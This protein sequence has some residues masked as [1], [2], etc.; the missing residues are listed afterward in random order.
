[1]AAPCPRSAQSRLEPPRP[2]RGPARSPPR[3]RPSATTRADSDCPAVTSG[4]S[5]WRAAQVAAAPSRLFAPAA[6]LPN[7]EVVLRALALCKQLRLQ[8]RRSLNRRSRRFRVTASGAA[9]SAGF[10]PSRISRTGAHARP[11]RAVLESSAAQ[12]SSGAC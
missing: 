7:A 8:R 12:R 4:A 2:P 1:M 11:A 3:G 10:A 6:P 9:A 5:A